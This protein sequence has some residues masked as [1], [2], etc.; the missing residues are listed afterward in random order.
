MTYRLSRKA[1]DDVIQIYV[2]GVARFGVDQAERYHDGLARAL[3]LLSAFPLAAPQRTELRGAP[4]IHPYK[5][6]IIIY[7]LDGAGI[8]VLRVRH[9][10]EDWVRHPD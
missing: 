10:L 4:R 7:R 2:D 8:F 3:D 6:H 9:A 1:E 5:S